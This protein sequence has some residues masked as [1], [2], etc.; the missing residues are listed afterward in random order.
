MNRP[1]SA[2]LLRLLLAMGVA[3]FLPGSLQACAV[4]M[5][6]PDSPL[7]QGM[8]AGVLL[9]LGVIVSVLV[10]IA[11]FFIFLAHNSRRVSGDGADPNSMQ[12]P[13]I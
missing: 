5:G 3:G 2:H 9:L 8:V 10:A 1:V 13:E 11:G 7:T 6:D 12:S 4:C